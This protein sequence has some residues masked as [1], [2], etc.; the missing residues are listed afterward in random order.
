[1]NVLQK[2]AF[3]SIQTLLIGIISLYW[4]S[5][6]CFSA[7]SDHKK[8]RLLRVPRQPAVCINGMGGRCG[9]GSIRWVGSTES[10]TTQRPG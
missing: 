1:M 4:A 10:F 9:V 7:A 6:N 5:G 2:S 3:T 8:R